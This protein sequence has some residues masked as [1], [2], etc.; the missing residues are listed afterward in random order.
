MCYIEYPNPMGWC[1]PFRPTYP[2]R[3]CCNCCC[4]CKCQCKCFR[5]YSSYPVYCSSGSCNLQEPFTV[6]NQDC[7]TGDLEEL[8]ILEKQRVVLDEEI[9]K[10]K[11]KL[12]GE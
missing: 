8:D 6:T 11:L 7:I 1:P 12:T 3:N 2:S 4:Q 5:T 10:L 9:R